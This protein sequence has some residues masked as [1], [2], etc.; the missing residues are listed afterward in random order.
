MSAATEMHAAVS[1]E[2][3]T[4]RFGDGVVAADDISLQIPEGQFLTLLGPSGC[5]KTTLLRIIAGL[6]RPTSGDVFL[7]GKRVTGLPAQQRRIGFTFQRY[8]LFP[9]LT[10]LENVAFPLKVRRV[11]RAERRERALSMLEL[12]HLPQLADRLPHE[13][14]GGQAQRVALA[15]A[16]AP[17]PTVMLL[18]EPLTALDLAVRMAMQEELRRIHRELGT[19]FVYVT[20]DQ[21]EALTMS[22][23]I[24]LMRDGEIVQDATPFEL[25]RTPGSLFAA[26]FVGEANVWSGHAVTDAAAD[27]RCEVRLDGLP[28]V[29]GIVRAQVSADAEVAYIVRPERITIDTDD[30][31]GIEVTVEDALPRGAHTVIV[32]RTGEGAAVRIE[33]SADRA[34]DLRREQRATVRWEPGDAFIFPGRAGDLVSRAPEDVPDPVDAG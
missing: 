12:V 15:R 14:S 29:E 6:E 27:A 2:R 33:V 9:H 26:T 4:K 10:V 7:A 17:E 13:I 22:D 8:A 5:G 11:S 16:L 18:D 20:H 25:Y 23:R 24:L 31:S 30:Q 34:V 3:I 32:T 1:L 28:V 19:T 21:G